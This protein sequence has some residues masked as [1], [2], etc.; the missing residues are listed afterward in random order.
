M[1]VDNN[2]QL[3]AEASTT[4]GWRYGIYE[5]PNNTN[6]IYIEEL[7]GTNGTSQSVNHCP[8]VAFLNGSTL[9]DFIIGSEIYGQT[10]S[11]GGLYKFTGTVQV[12]NN[13]TYVAFSSIY[14]G[15]EYAADMNAM[16]TFN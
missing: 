6:S 3:S 9:S 2:N 5:L 7:V 13:A 14:A 4:G 16:I 10:T 15:S 1:K 12:P 8:V 11:G